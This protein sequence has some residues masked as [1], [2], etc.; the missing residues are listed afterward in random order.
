M[1]DHYASYYL[2]ANLADTDTRD[3]HLEQ[4]LQEICFIKNWQILKDL[5]NIFGI[6]DDILVVGFDSDGK[7]HNYILWKL[8][9]ICIQVNLKLN[10]DECHYRCTSI[11][12]FDGGIFRHGEQPNP[13]KMKVL[14]EMPP[15]KM[16][17]ELQ[18]F[19][20]II[21]Y[22]GKFS[23]STADICESLRKLTSAKTGWTWNATYQE[24]FDKARSI[25]KEDACMKFYNETKPL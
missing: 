16:K 10:K 6:A 20:G 21:N 4:H 23:P 3:Y 14:A 18:A 12:F 7:D 5:P 11:L 1:M 2:H 8:L 17:I 15:P 13:W 25:I 9:Q 24:I 22:L 19:L